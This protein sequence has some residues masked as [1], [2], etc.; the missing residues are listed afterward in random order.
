MSSF[1]QNL[2]AAFASFN[3]SPLRPRSDD[4]QR[5]LDRHRRS[6]LSKQRAHSPSPHRRSPPSPTAGSRRRI[7]RAKNEFS[8][9]LEDNDHS[10]ADLGFEFPRDI[11]A[12]QITQSYANELLFTPGSARPR[13]QLR[14]GD[15]SQMMNK[16]RED[17][18]RLLPG[19]TFRPQGA[20][21][22]RPGAIRAMRKKPG[23]SAAFQPTDRISHARQSGPIRA[24]GKTKNG[25]A[26]VN[27]TYRQ[28]EDAHDFQ[29]SD[30]P[31]K[32]RRHEGSRLVDLTHE[33]QAGSVTSEISAS[34]RRSS[35]LSPGSNL[36][37]SN[38]RNRARAPFV[39][40]Y[41]G[42]EAMLERT[43]HPRPTD[44]RTSNA[45]S[46]DEL[47]T[48]EA[49]AE[50]RSSGT[51]VEKADKHHTQ[52]SLDSPKLKR[53]PLWTIE[54]PDPEENHSEE[55]RPQTDAQPLTP[56][57]RPPAASDPGD[58]PDELQGEVTTRPPPKH[59]AEKGLQNC[60]QSTPED[61]VLSPPR[62]RS[63]SDIEPTRFDS[64]RKKKKAKRGQPNPEYR[65]LPIQSIRFG[66]IHKLVKDGEK[67][68]I[69]LSPDKILLGKDITGDRPEGVLF[70]HVRVTYQAENSQKVRL[71]LNGY[72]GAPGSKFDIHFTLRSS[73]DALVE[74]IR[75][76]G[77]KVQDKDSKWIDDAFSTYD[78]EM[79]HRRIPPRSPLQEITELEP[80]TPASTSVHQ[81][82]GKKLSSLLEGS[83]SE[84]DGQAQDQKKG[85]PEEGSK[86]MSSVELS[87][88]TTKDKPKT[89]DVEVEIPVKKIKSKE[90]G[91][92]E[93][94]R[95]TRTTTRRKERSDDDD[96]STNK[97]DTALQNDSF[98]DN[99]K[100]PLVYPKVGK[101]KE[102][103]SVDDRDRLRENEFLN[104]NLIAFYIRFLQDHLE[105]TN[106]DVAKRVY[107]FNTYFFATLTNKGSREINY[108]GVEKWTR[109]V[110]L[111][112][113][114]YIVVPINQNAHW[115]V[116]IICNLP[117]LGLGPVKSLG[118]SSAPLSDKESLARPE[119]E[120]QELLESPEPE[121]VPSPG[122]LSKKAPAEERKPDFV[123]PP[124]EETRKSFASMTLIERKNALAQTVVQQGLSST[125]EAGQDL[126]EASASQAA[127]QTVRQDGPASGQIGKA[128]PK[129][130]RGGVKLEPDQTAIVTFDSLDANRS[131]TVKVLREY[132]CKE[133]DSKRKVEIKNPS[134]VIKGMRAQNIPLQPNY[135]DCGLYLLAYMECF[136]RNPDEFITKV[137]RREM[138]VDEDWP[139][140][141]SGLLRLRMRN[142][143]DQ[144]YQ[145]QWSDKKED[146]MVD[147]QP[148]SFLLGPPKAPREDD[149][150]DTKAVEKE[151]PTSSLKVNKAIGEGRVHDQSLQEVE[152]SDNEATDMPVLVPTAA[153]P[154]QKPIKRTLKPSTP[155]PARSRPPLNEIEVETIPDSQEM[156]ASSIPEPKPGRTEK[157][158]FK[159]AKA[160]ISSNE[161]ERNRPTTPEN[162]S[163]RGLD[164]ALEESASF[165]RVEIQVPQ[166]PP[167]KDLKQL[168][169]SPRGLTRK[170]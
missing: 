159:Q 67:A 162:S 124:S 90:S 11:A 75:E 97:P 149:H 15:P 27:M 101:K 140:L 169:H 163:A 18:A 95:S 135:S 42:V 77:G 122:R 19:A 54:I 157:K 13:G 16:D 150:E 100:K 123:S 118:T 142:F 91:E 153:I 1:F 48:W 65:N 20:F 12:S 71:Q 131:P 47:F 21:E 113:Y 121:T 93:T 115:Y 167:R 61:T 23:A 116:A 46:A 143:L 58:S 166:T 29:D 89:T 8:L 154:V 81:M 14:P 50:R 138:N 83:A 137:L 10:R 62:K 96:P 94:R 104:D 147:R 3:S 56:S 152:A 2:S 136:V 43:H 141:G 4:P 119:K 105:R 52:P 70:R 76:G 145:E 31:N 32:R 155:E 34:G 33:D 60:R 51:A 132:I 110:D 41:R 64:P 35:R 72:Q 158:K 68:V 80:K 117:S 120:V 6:S 106:P 165:P 114:D 103:V 49:A 98:R 85:K 30:R 69:Q 156:A 28:L 148:I 37:I 112:N 168:R 44:R 22:I 109:A 129:K 161:R 130:K 7:P 25:D 128:K 66:P 127:K 84:S 82:K 63:P 17:E 108:E 146:L 87:R 170:R 99:W 139:P 126:E 45:S 79:C 134:S 55:A 88:G 160:D 39:S 107:F 36:S 151:G 111:F 125:A 74:R 73:K 24:S 92:S 102:E 38:P 144:L 53:A 86:L 57:R 26:F 164:L 9:G 133:A 40:E 78:N 5:P 59:L